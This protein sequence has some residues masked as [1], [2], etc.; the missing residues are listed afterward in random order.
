MFF[1]QYSLLICS[2]EISDVTTFCCCFEIV[3]QEQWENAVHIGMVLF[4][5]ITDGADRTR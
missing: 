4:S 2:S 5:E 1:L 3:C